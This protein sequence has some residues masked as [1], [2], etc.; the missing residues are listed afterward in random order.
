MKPTDSYFESLAR[1][2]CGTRWLWQYEVRWFSRDVGSPPRAVEGWEYVRQVAVVTECDPMIYYKPG[3]TPLKFL[4][5]YLLDHGIACVFLGLGVQPISRWAG[6][7][8]KH[9]PWRWLAWILNRLDAGHTDEAGGLLWQ[10]TPCPAKVR[11]VVMACWA[12]I[13]GGLVLW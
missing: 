8:V 12:L 1:W 2:A 9:A 13:L 7:R 11:L 5:V 10:T 4:P 3:W 6:Q